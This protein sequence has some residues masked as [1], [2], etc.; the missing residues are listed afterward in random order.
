M[1]SGIKQIFATKL[2]DI[3]T[4]QREQLGTI[5]IEG[6]KVYKYCLIQNTTATVAGAAGSLVGYFAA[7]GYTSH[8]VVIDLTDADSQPS[9]AGALCGTVTGTAG[10]A[11]Y[12][13]VQIKGACTLDTA[14]I[15]GTAGVPFHLTTTDK[16]GQRSNEADSTGAYKTVMGRCM[17]STTGVILDAPF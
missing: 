8:R 13:W 14:I 4:V 11:Y 17:N 6:N 9:G 3:D 15:N 5:R 10:T 7:T 2:T 12:G 1:S 16:T